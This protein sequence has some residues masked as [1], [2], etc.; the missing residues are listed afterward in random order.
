MFGHAKEVFLIAGAGPRACPDAY[1]NPKQG[2]HRES[3][4]TGGCRYNTTIKTIGI[5]IK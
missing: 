4:T 2:N 1:K 3:A 5:N